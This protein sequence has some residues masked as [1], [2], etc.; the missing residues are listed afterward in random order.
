MVCNVAWADIAQKWTASPV[1]PWGTT[2]VAS[3]NYPAGVATILTNAHGGKGTVRLAETAVTAPSNGTAT[4]QFVY[5]GGNH[6]MNIL[7]VD[8]INA[9]GVVVASDYHHGTAGG[10]H[11]NNTYT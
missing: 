11:S 10:S 1:A 4:V 8:L 9:G 5:S 7:G 3:A 6:K 2:D